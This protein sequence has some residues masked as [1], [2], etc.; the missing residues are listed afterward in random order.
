MENPDVVTLKF[1]GAKSGYIPADQTGPISMMFSMDMRMRP[2]A[3]HHGR[4]YRFSS[5][6]SS[7]LGWQEP[8]AATPVQPFG[9][10]GRRLSA[11]FNRYAVK[12]KELHLLT[13]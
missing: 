3:S 2:S 4:F 5:G 10:A 9:A 1:H 6:E 13:T 7:F 12:A 11:R 8:V